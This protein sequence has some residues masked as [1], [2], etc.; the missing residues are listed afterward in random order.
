MDKD[1]FRAALR[2]L[3]M[4]QTLLRERLGLNKST[5]SRYAKGQLSVPLWMAV[6]LETEKKLRETQ[7]ELLTRGA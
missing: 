5:T 3:G 2:D 1:Q 6:Y 7:K 4:T